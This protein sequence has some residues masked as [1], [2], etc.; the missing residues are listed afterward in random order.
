MNSKK[1]EVVEQEG[2]DND[3]EEVEDLRD[4]SRLRISCMPHMRGKLE[5]MGL[6]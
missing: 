4:M 6:V 2:L 1:R 5:I 3:H